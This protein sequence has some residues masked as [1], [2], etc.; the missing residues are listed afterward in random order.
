MAEVGARKWIITVTVILASVIEIIDTSIVNVALPHMMG[1]LSATLDEVAW[2]ITSYVVANVIVLPMT[3]WLSMRFGRRNYFVGSILLFTAASFFCGQ[4]TSIWELVVFRLIQGIGGG[5]LLSTSQSILVETFPPEELGFANGLFGLGVV[6]GPTVGPTLGGWITD[7]F[8]WRWI[9]Y[10]NLP[11]GL[12]AA[13]CAYSFIRD[14][15]HTERQG[16]TDWLG[17]ILLIVGIGALQIFLERGEAEDW[18]E[19]TYITVLCGVSVIGILCFIWRELATEHPIV[20]LRVLKDGSLALGTVCNFILGFGLYASVFILPVFA[21]NLLGFTATQT[22]IVMLRGALATMIMMP[23]VGKLLERGAPSYILTMIGFVLVFTFTHMVS[24][25]SLAS[26]EWDFFWPLI[27][28]GMGMSMSF[29]PLTTLALSGLKGPAIAQ[30]AGFTNMMR[31]LGGSFGVAL[32]ATF[33]QR[34]VFAHRLNLT[35]YISLYDPA[36]QQRLHT[37]QQG[38]AARGG[39][40]MAQLQQQSHAVI[41]ATVTRQSVLL[42]YLDAFRVVGLF[43]LI[44]APLF[45]LFAFRTKTPDAE[46]VT[47]MAH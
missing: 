24:E 17:I 36:V 28:R 7:S 18:F 14:H 20:N 45:L 9:F 26:G 41:E 43:F 19:T 1:N 15:E 40:T 4:A 21:Q 8:S 5:A 23:L 32:V 25:F 12:L 46:P 42:S 33:V 22:G 35:R 3:G 27:I 11:I 44:C 39:G 2:V 16:A 6:M 47:V 29:V 38:L 10:I 30:G 13:F 34:H 37:I 31:Q